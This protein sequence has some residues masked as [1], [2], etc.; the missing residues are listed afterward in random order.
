MDDVFVFVFVCVGV[1]GAVFFQQGGNGGAGRRDVFGFEDAFGVSV[2]CFSALLERGEWMV[3]VGV[4]WNSAA[5]RDGI[6]VGGGSFQS[7]C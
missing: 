1:G 7:L 5:V 3:F 6:M 2:R 4:L